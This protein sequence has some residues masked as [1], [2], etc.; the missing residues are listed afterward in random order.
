MKVIIRKSFP[1]SLLPILLGVSALLSTLFPAGAII[2]ATL[3]MQ[4]G[5]PTGATADTNNHDHYLIQRTVEAIDYNDNLGQPNWASWDLTAADRRRQRAHGDFTTD[6]SLPSNFNLIPSSTYGSIGGQ[7]YDRGHMCP[8]ADRTDTVADNKL[9]FIMSN[10][11]PQASAQNEQVWGNFEN[12]CRSLISTQELL[13]MCGPYNFGTNR[14]DSG[15]GRRCFKHVEDRGRR[16]AGR[17][18]GAQPHY[19]RQPQLDSRHRPRNPQ[20]R[21][22]GSQRLDHLRHLRQTDSKRHRL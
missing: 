16:S 10:I 21:R 9:V 4:L 1:R 15:I 13:I 19:Q 14:L 11:I 7:S 17:R 18:D 3:Q 22:C 6:T 12:Y 5:N 8:S 20:H 2:D